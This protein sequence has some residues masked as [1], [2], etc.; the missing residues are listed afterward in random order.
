MLKMQVLQIG[1]NQ[2]YARLLIGSWE[3]GVGS[4]ELGVGSYELR[5][6]SWSW[7]LGVGS[8]T[9]CMAHL[10]DHMLSEVCMV[11]SCCLHP[12]KPLQNL[13]ASNPKSTNGHKPCQAM[14][15]VKLTEHVSAELVPG[16]RFSGPGRLAM[17]VGAV[18]RATIY[19]HY[20]YT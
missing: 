17:C 12:I 11:C 4:W 9:T 14:H 3:L 18:R 1:V 8:W 13:H 20:P 2:V 5:V 6:A 7:E 10:V 15:A 19:Q 16:I